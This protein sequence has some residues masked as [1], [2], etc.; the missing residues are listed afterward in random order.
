MTD[1]QKTEQDKTLAILNAII[2]ILGIIIPAA[3]DVYIKLKKANVTLDDLKQLA[4]LVMRP[5]EYFSPKVGGT[6]DE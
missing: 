3:A 4:P 1:Q 2:Q 5:E 6:S